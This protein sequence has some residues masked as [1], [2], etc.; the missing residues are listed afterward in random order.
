MSMRRQV[1]LAGKVAVVT[2]GGRGLGR[3]TALAFAAA[4]AKVVVV[5]RTKDELEKVVRLM[6]DDNGLAVTGDVSEE[7]TAIR[8]MEAAVERF[9]GVDILMNNAAMV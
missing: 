6:G 5:S 1:N 2:G 8:V 7:A 4:G 3:A 9:G